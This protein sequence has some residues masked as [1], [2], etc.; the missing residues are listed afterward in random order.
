MAC[1]TSATL[2]AA[3]S[4]A[5]WSWVRLACRKFRTRGLDSLFSGERFRPAGWGT[6]MVKSKIDELKWEMI[7]DRLHHHRCVPF[8]GA[9]ANIRNEIRRYV[10][11]P[12]GNDVA[13]A[14]ATK[15][16][17]GEGQPP[18]LARIALEYEVRTDRPYLLQFL[19]EMLDDGDI[20]PSPLLRTLAAL[21]LKLVVTTN[22]DRLL[23]R[24]LEL[25]QTPFETLV[26]PAEGFEDTPETRER[27]ESLEQYSGTIVYKI[28]G[29]F[30]NHLAGR[31]KDYDEDPRSRIII[32]EDDYIDFLTVHEKDSVKI[33][34]PNLIRKSITPSTL[35]F[36]GYSLQDWDFRT[37]Y[38]GL[39]ERL[40]K[41]QA[42]KSFAIQHNPPEYWGVYWEKKGIE[43]YSMDVYDFAEEL[44]HRYRKKYGEDEPDG[45]R[46][47]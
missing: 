35:L 14:F 6:G 2:V 44:G 46:D 34:V 32:T 42:R 20:E 33:G 31:G 17:Y 7:I 39:V 8:L 47:Q 36:L 13:H 25:S 37:I 16:Q 15:L 30:G 5:R 3:T 24:A 10:G 1:S 40:N 45:R 43:I 12:L 9:A 4:S 38:R 26:Q 22:Y 28:H 11:L 27:L 21:P 29:T 18:E 23:E 41:H 19:R